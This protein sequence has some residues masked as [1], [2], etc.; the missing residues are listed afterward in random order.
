MSMNSSHSEHVVMLSKCLVAF[1]TSKQIGTREKRTYRSRRHICP[2]F[3]HIL[4][5]SNAETKIFKRD[6]R[7]VRK[8]KDTWC[9]A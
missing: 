3:R 5:K 9:R 2:G 4:G 1:A 6:T 7:S 8:S